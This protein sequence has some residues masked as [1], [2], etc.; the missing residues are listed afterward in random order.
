MPGACS[1]G[2]SLSA[3]Q[4]SHVSPWWS[5]QVDAGVLK[6]LQGAHA[7]SVLAGVLAVCQAGRAA[8]VAGSLV[9]GAAAAAPVPIPVHVLPKA[10]HNEHLYLSLLLI[11]S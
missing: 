2:S 5:S 10:S 3:Q 9:D 11:F 8:D 6:R 7:G 1:Q 4:L